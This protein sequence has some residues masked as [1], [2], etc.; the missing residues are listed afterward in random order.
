[1][2]DVGT[3]SFRG[4]GVGL[5]SQDG[6]RGCDLG[7]SGADVGAGRAHGAGALAGV[8]VAR[9][10]RGVEGEVRGGLRHQLVGCGRGGR[11][12]GELTC[13]DLRDAGLVAR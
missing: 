10:R 1:M 9:P 8:L 3:W 2:V 4:E 6:E 7:E 5:A 13:C 12:S 11:C